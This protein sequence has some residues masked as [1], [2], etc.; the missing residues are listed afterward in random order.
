MDG[1][2]YK[3]QL[4]DLIDTKVLQKMQDAFSDMLNVAALTTD[5]EGVAVTEGSNFSDFCIKYTRSSALGCARCKQCD[6]EGAERALAWGEPVIYNCH[7]GLMDF[8]APIKVDGKIVGCFIGGQV[9]TEPPN[10][11]R[12]RE[13]AREIGVDPEEYLAAVYKVKVFGRDAVKKAASFL[14]TIADALSSMAQNQYLVHKANFE[15]ARSENMK[16]DFLANMS[17]EIR[18]PMNAVIGM[19]EMALREQLPVAAREYITQIKEAG[20]SLLTIINDILDF[21]KIESG[22]MDISEVDY[23]PM[24]IVYDVANIVMTRLKDKDVELVL[25]IAPNLPSRLF[26]DNIRIKQILLN[27]TNNAAKFTTHGKIVVRVDYVDMD[28]DRIE[29]RISVEDTGIGIREE[30]IGKLFQSFQQLDS[31]RNRNIEGTGLG[32]AISQRLLTLM[33]G[34]IRLESEYEKGSKFSFSLPQKIVNPTPSICLRES[35]PRLVVGLIS[36]PYVRESLCSD[37]AH[38]GVDYLGVSGLKELAVLP[39]DKKLFLFIE[40]PMFSDGVEA[41]VRCNPQV[42]AVLLIDFYDHVS[43]DIPNLLILR[44]P[45]FALNIA[46][47]LNEEELNFSNDTDEKE[48]DFI[49][50]DA[51]VLIVDDNV[52]NLTV[53]EGLLEPLKMRIDTATSGKAAIDKITDFHYDIVFMDHMMPEL[54]G[55]ETTHIIR[56]FHPEYDD[57]P[58]IALTANAVDGTKEMFCREGMNDFVA[59][60]IEMRILAAKVRQWLPVEKIQKVYSAASSEQPEKAAEPIVIGDLDVKYAMGII[61]NEELFWKV[62]KVFYRS[63]DKKVR[64]I[65]ALEEQEDWINYTIEVHALKNAARQIGAIQLSDR[66]AAL[67]KAGNARNSEVIHRQTDEMLEQYSGYLSV[68]EPFCAEEEEEEGKQSISREELADCFRKLQAA[69]DDLDMDRMEEVILEMNQYHYSDWQLKLFGQLKDA[70]EE[71]DVDRCEE[72]MQSWREKL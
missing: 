20:K 7:A 52:V 11:D 27:I 55:V 31:K 12:I 53:A 67:E 21:S 44:K 5:A 66:A 6:R 14:F 59:K 9:L 38:L 61:S 36:N 28:S 15:L 2:D 62:L 71:I 22:K 46:M 17:H 69:V 24:S 60:P 25:D 35:E 47:I 50:P 72:I 56:R 43:Y 33:D 16:S 10:P 58:I 40:H 4:A 63:I 65:K 49:A 13:I 23:E 64:L 70:V 48:F 51:E 37:V 68:L 3:I 8:A 30:D 18:T 54:D 29:L 19:A 45:L 1:M 39:N 34:E 57:V 32:L 42:T 41:Y 26:G